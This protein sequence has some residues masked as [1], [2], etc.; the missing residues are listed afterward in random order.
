MELATVTVSAV[1]ANTTLEHSLCSQLYV[2]YS[3]AP[4]PSPARQKSH[5]FT[6]EGRR[7]TEG[8]NVLPCF[9]KK[10]RMITQ[11]SETLRNLL[12]M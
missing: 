12:E 7:G 5:H 4:S 2:N 6:D 3:P 11:F 8:S 9:K 1:A 10:K